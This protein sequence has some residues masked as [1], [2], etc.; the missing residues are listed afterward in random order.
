MVTRSGL[1][2]LAALVP[3]QAAVY[4]PYRWFLHTSKCCMTKTLCYTP[5]LIINQQC[6]PSPADHHEDSKFWMHTKDSTVLCLFPLN[7]NFGW[8]AFLRLSLP[9]QTFQ[10]HAISITMPF[11]HFFAMA[12]TFSF[13]LCTSL[14]IFLATGRA[15]CELLVSLCCSDLGRALC[16]FPEVHS[17]FHNWEGSFHCLHYFLGAREGRFPPLRSLPVRFL[18]F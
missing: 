13:C 3:D 11:D 4:Q 16:N 2:V 7:G 17:V 1:T 12:V 6:S 5:S 8:S 15:P 9:V 18:A 10:M 14:V